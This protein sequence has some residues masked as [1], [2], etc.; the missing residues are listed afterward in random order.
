MARNS[1]REKAENFEKEAEILRRLTPDGILYG[2][3]IA[4]KYEKAAEM[5]EAAGERSRAEMALRDA[6]LLGRGNPDYYKVGKSKDKMRTLINDEHFEYAVEDA[7]ARAVKA[8]LSKI[9][10]MAKTLNTK[11]KPT[12]AIFSIVS[13]L[14]AL[15]LVSAQLTGYAILGIERIELRDFAVCFFVCGLMF[16]FLYLNGKKKAKK[17]K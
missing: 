17:K 16:A 9:E 12:M 5:W 10:K 4:A 7:R 2:E 14:F 1:Y 15:F 11:G 8:A 3:K 13:L 6:E